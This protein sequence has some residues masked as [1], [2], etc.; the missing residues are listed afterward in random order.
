MHGVKCSFKL[1]F[2]EKL[3]H[4]NEPGRLTLYRLCHLLLNV[5][6]LLIIEYVEVVRKLDTP[7]FVATLRSFNYID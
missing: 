1:V 3:V 4:E 5:T 6:I 7:F 2:F